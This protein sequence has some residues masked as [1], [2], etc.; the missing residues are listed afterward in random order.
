MCRIQEKDRIHIS[1]DFQ[2]TEGEGDGQEL[3]CR[4]GIELPNL[5][6]DAGRFSEGQPRQQDWEVTH[7]REEM[8]GA[9]S[10]AAISGLRNKTRD[11]VPN[12]S[13]AEE[14][15]SRSTHFIFDSIQ[16]RTGLDVGA[17]S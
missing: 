10:S 9:R 17:I 7:V 16:V 3:E 15:Q 2:N 13:N 14:G 12:Y 4:S 5:W 11:F 1:D 6:L 8:L